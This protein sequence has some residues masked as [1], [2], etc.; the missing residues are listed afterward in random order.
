MEMQCVGWSLLKDT[1]FSA[2]HRIVISY[3]ACVRG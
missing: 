1:A 2:Y 3:E